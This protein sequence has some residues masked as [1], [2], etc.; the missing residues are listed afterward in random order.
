MDAHDVIQSNLPDQTESD[1]ELQE[2]G[3]EASLVVLST[4]LGPETEIPPDPSIPV[5]IIPDTPPESVCPA[6][7]GACTGPL[8]RCTAV[9]C[10][11]CNEWLHKGCYEGLN[12]SGRCL[13]CPVA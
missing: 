2:E 12:I 5:S 9:Q 8:R 7:C 1:D 6:E 11:F 10:P 3:N 4:T 13:F